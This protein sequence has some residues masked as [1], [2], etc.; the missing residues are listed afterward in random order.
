MWLDSNKLTLNVS[1][2]KVMIFG[3]SKKVKHKSLDV[4]IDGA[5]LDMVNSFKYLG[6]HLDSSLNWNDHI[7]YMCTKI[8]KRIGVLSRIRGYVSQKTA[9]LLYNSTILPVFD[10]C[11]VLWSNT[12]AK[13][14]SRIQRLQNRAARVILRAHGRTHVNDMLHKLKWLNVVDRVTYHKSLLV[15]KC[16]RKLVPEYLVDIFV[17]VNTVHHYNTRQSKNMFIHRMEKGSG[18]KSF[19]YSGAKLFNTF[20]ENLKQCANSKE[21]KKQYFKEHRINY[22]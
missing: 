21:F 19:K 8:A 10:Y 13:N 15:F 9:S 18:I 2:T 16:Y 5:K 14:L 11:D 22:A 20:S 7:D 1:K 12:S 17:P 6:A 4:N 3:S